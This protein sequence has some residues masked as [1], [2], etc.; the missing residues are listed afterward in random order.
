MGGFVLDKSVVEEKQNRIH[1]KSKT[2][3]GL[4]YMALLLF[5][6]CGELWFILT[7]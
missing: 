7:N 2:F 5:I 4:L 3:F 6:F 1:Q